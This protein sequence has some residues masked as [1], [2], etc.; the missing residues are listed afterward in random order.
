MNNAAKAEERQGLTDLLN[1]LP[2]H[3]PVWMGVSSLWMGTFAAPELPVRPIFGCLTTH[4]VFKSIL[5]FYF[6]RCSENVPISSVSKKSSS[7]RLDHILDPLET[8]KSRTKSSWIPPLT[9]KRIYTILVENGTP[10]WKLSVPCW[11]KAGT[12]LSNS[13]TG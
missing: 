5:T 6:S 8:V 11:C 12:H 3:L 10:L 9:R 4:L 1:A 13:K 2:S 7:N